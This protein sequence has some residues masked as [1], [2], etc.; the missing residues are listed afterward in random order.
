MASNHSRA[1][2]PQPPSSFGVPGDVKFFEKGCSAGKYWGHSTCNVR[3]ASNSALY[4]SRFIVLAGWGSGSRRIILVAPTPT[5][6]KEPSRG[7]AVRRFFRRFFRRFSASSPDF[8]V[9]SSRLVMI[10]PSEPISSEATRDQLSQ[11]IAC[12]YRRRFRG[13]HKELRRSDYGNTEIPRT[14]KF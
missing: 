6:V 11:R 2:S 8:P 12:G 7:G 10:T 13:T 4:L 14:R 9:Y 5:N 1:G 3:R